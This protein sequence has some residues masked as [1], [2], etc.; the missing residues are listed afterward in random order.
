MPTLRPKGAQRCK[1]SWYAAGAANTGR[2]TGSGSAAPRERG[3]AEGSAKGATGTAA[4]ATGVAAA[5]KDGA[6]AT[7]AAAAP[8]DG[9]HGTHP[10]R[11]G[12]H[13]E[14]EA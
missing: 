10:D 14:R 6:S 9:S 2:R 3:S 7:G 8:R 13:A 1:I 11:E 12:G 4:S 5:P